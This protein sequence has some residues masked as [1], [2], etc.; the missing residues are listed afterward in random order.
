MTAVHLVACLSLAS[1]LHRPQTC[2]RN[3]ALFLCY[4]RP[5]LLPSSSMM[6]YAL[7]ARLAT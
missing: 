3:L 4:T 5:S 1:C 6:M 2:T 7:L